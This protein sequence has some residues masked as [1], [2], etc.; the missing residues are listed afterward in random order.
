MGSIG[1][2]LRMVPLWLDSFASSSERDIPSEETPSINLVGT[3]SNSLLFRLGP[4]GIILLVFG[5]FSLLR[6]LWN[7]HCNDYPMPGFN[8]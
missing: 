3:Y 5:K 1:S 6:P 4:G 8:F 7:G 2:S